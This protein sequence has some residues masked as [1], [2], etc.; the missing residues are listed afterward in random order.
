MAMREHIQRIKSESG[1]RGVSVPRFSDTKKCEWRKRPESD[2][3]FVWLPFSVMLD[4]MDFAL[5]HAI[6]RMPDGSLIRQREGIPMGDPLSPAMTVITCAWMEDEWL[7][8]VATR[9]KTCFT[10]RRYMDDILMVYAKPMWW[11]HER[12]L[13][14][15]TRSEC[16]WPPLKLEDAKENTFLETTFEIR[17]NGELTYWLKNDNANEKKIWRYQHWRSHAP[18]AQKK[19]LVIA[20]LRKVHKMTSDR[21]RRYLSA[22]D[23]LREFIALDYPINLLRSSCNLLSF[24]TGD[25]TW[26]GVRNTID[27][28]DDTRLREG[29]RTVQRPVR[30]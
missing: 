22:L 10:A 12:F 17:A 29:Q 16:Y 6:V 4:V 13:R 28:I 18:F 23:K 25:T 27:N 24:S 7:Q 20:C 30:N 2:R 21:R 15:F 19:A 5:D 26:I 11:D 14:D 3:R 9:D 8:T 1:Q